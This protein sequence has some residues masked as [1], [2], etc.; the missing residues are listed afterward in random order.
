MKYF[1]GA[2]RTGPYFEGWYLKH[3]TRDGRVLA[4]IPA[5]HMDSGGRRSASLQVIAG[6][7]SWWLE[8]PDR[9]FYADKEGFRVKVGRSCFC[10]RGAK[11]EIHREGLSLR[12]RVSYGPFAPLGRDIMGPFRLLGGMQC[13]HGVLSMGHGLRGWMELNG[14]RLDLSG[15][16]GYI[17]TDRGRSFPDRYLWTQCGWRDGGLMLAIATIPLPIGGFTGCICAILHRGRE[18][19]LATYCGAKIEKWSS[20]GAEI[21][22]GSHRLTAE[23]LEERA[24]P[25]YAPAE[26]RMERT[27]HESPSARVRY[28]FWKGKELLFRH[29]DRCAGFEYSDRKEAGATAAAPWCGGAPPARGPLPR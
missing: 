6:E 20:A 10:R 18:Y 3:Q 11:V 21:R 17:E 27:I 24:R 2:N 22:Q 7:G 23:L 19:R 8:Y 14:E 12:G 25:L 4:L 9:D 29:T 13:S 15:G 5:F 1:H 16:L 26:G 28:S